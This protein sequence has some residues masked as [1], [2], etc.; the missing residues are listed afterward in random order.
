MAS[1]SGPMNAS[2]PSETSLHGLT[3]WPGAFA[4]DDG[5]LRMPAT[6]GRL[7]VPV[8]RDQPC[9]QQ[10]EIAYV[11]LGCR[12]KP[13]AAPIVVLAG[14]PGGSGIGDLM[15]ERE[16]LEALLEVGDVIGVDQRGVGLSRPRLT[17]CTVELLPLEQPLDRQTIIDT[18]RRHAKNVGTWWAEAGVDL[19]GF[20][21]R[22]SAADIDDLRR[23]LRL[24][25]ICLSGESYGS[26]LGLAILK[27][28]GDGIERAMLGLVEGPD[29]TLKLP[30][31]I[32][33]FFDMITAELAAQSWGGGQLPPL[34]EMMAEVH[35]RLRAAP[36]RLPDAVDGLHC[37]W[38]SE[39][40]LQYLAS[41]ALGDVAALQGLP[42][43]YTGLWQGRVDGVVPLLS[44]WRG[45]LDDGAMSMAM[46]SA[47]SGTAERR[48]R[49]EAERHASLLGD[50]VNLPFPYIAGDIGAL[51][52]G[53]G[54]RSP[55][56]S[57]VPTLLLTGSHDGRTPAS[58]A[59]AVQ[60][61]LSRSTHVV[62]HGCGHHL[63]S[64]SGYL[65]DV[66]AF[67]RGE[68]VVDRG[69]RRVPVRFG[70]PA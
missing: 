8:R 67:L 16:V 65:A 13:A 37:R 26:H 27:A 23:A 45:E 69:L 4:S 56:H 59:L 60:A 31:N 36:L 49:V 15:R 24:E 54:F 44:G 32:D 12:R 7:A 55:V 25:K 20:N 48:A 33:R 50:V 1:R 63:M 51:D 3:E 53:D 5:R 34:R 10:L 30:S 2:Q 58:N 47:S 28:H 6:W 9:A 61:G 40:V 21:T 42:A 39:T 43:L 35:S 22:E 18:Y 19:A 29:D 17:A 11:R 66:Q 46:D 68:E 38:L 64:A 57:A 70:A 52:L 62:L 14:G 41:F